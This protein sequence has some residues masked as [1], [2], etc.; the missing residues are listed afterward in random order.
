MCYSGSCPYEKWSGECGKKSCQN[1]PAEF[2]TAEEFYEEMER[3]EEERLDRLY[4][5]QIGRRF[6]T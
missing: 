2:D 1:C 4:E 3:L 6:Y 5:T